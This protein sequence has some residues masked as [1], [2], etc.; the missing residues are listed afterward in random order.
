ML[1]VRSLENCFDSYKRIAYSRLGH[2]FNV[3][4]K[5]IIFMMYGSFADNCMLVIT[6]VLI[7][8][9]YDTNI[10]RSYK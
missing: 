3:V 8:I 10:P 9:F 6:T 5:M 1:V 2:R 7:F 4:R